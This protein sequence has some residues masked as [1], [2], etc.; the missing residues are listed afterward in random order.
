MICAVINKKVGENIMSSFDVNHFSF[1]KGKI[2]YNGQKKKTFDLK[3]FDGVSRDE[4]IKKAGGENTSQGKL[5]SSIFNKYDNGDGILTKEEY[6]K[7]QN[8]LVQF[9][10]DGN[11]GEREF[12]RF[13]ENLGTKKNTFKMQ[14]L[15]SVIGMMTDSTDGVATDEQGNI[16][17]T[18]AAEDGATITSKY[19]NENN[20]LT[21]LSKTVVN[22]NV[23][24]VSDYSNEKLLKD[25]V[26]DNGVTT[27][28]DYV[29]GDKNK[30]SKIVETKGNA[31]TTTLY[32]DDGTTISSKTRVTGAVTEDLDFANNDRVMKKTTIKGNVEEIVEYEY[33]A[34]GIVFET[35]HNGDSEKPSQ[36]VRKDKNGTVT[37]TYTYEYNDDGSY[38]ETETTGTGENA[39]SVR[40]AYNNSGNITGQV[41]VDAEGKPQDYKHK[42][43]PGQTWYN[44]VRAKYGV[45]DHKQI[46]EIVHQL[47]DLA[48]IKRS[49]VSAPKEITLPATITLKNGTSIELKNTGALVNIAGSVDA[50]GRPIGPRITPPK[51]LAKDQ[52]PP[53]IAPLAKSERKITIPTSFSKP[54]A[55]TPDGEF[56]KI[57]EG[58]FVGKFYTYHDGR[59]YIYDDEAA[60]DAYNNSVY[61]GYKNGKVTIYKLK[62]YD[63]DGNTAGIIRY[64]GTGKLI[65]RL[66]NDQ[67]PEGA[68]NSVQFGR[69][70]MYNADGS[71]DHIIA[72]NQYDEQGRDSEYDSFDANGNW[73]CSR[74][75][76][77]GNDGTMQ[78][79]YY[80]AGDRGRMTKIEE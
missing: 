51:K 38:T 47:K 15:Q 68:K 76:D 59:C 26:V 11:L 63:T 53:K 69:Q 27:V 1:D 12:D 4:L 28:T 70:I 72:N 37:D 55:E 31:V 20:V 25:T 7:L 79:R 52:I 78:V 58:E 41:N 71:V 6:Q 2:D 23:K 64:D 16:L 46:M 33:D 77:Y 18:S 30:K 42:V 48:G 9:A 8:D 22:G 5:L 66:I 65:Y 74:R 39:V 29:D 24:T 75:I 19:S 73:S 56:V 35:T 67:Y 45:T 44:I 61:I 13:E 43:E 60:R 49:S 62:T 3:N 80:A 34:D 17:L 21:L 36:I 40:T 57:T 54:P 14:D 10:K 32:A 50:N